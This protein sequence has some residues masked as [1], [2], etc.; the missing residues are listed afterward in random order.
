MIAVIMPEGISIGETI[1]LPIRSEIHRKAPPQTADRGIKILL[2]AP[3][4]N[5]TM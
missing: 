3:V 1:D 5:L 2:S 4:I